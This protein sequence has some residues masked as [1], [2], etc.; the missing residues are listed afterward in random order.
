MKLLIKDGRIIDPA[1]GVDSV[2]DLLIENG[3]IKAMEDCLCV[4]DARVI[5]AAG[6]V[7]TPGFIDMHVH[8]R[9]PGYTHK[10]TIYTGTR[11]AVMG[12]ITSLACMPNT[13]P[14]IDG[15]AIVALIKEKARQEGVASVYPI[16]CVTKKCEGKELAGIASMKKAGVVALSDDGMPV[17]SSKVMRRVMEYASMFGLPIISHCEEKELSGKGVM[18]EGAM[19]T[20]LGLKGIPSAAENVMIARDIE[21]AKLTGAH[22]HIAHLSTKEGVEMVRKAKEAGINVTAEVTP[23]HF[24]LTDESLS[25]YDTNLKVN[26]PLRTAEDREEILNG[27]ADGTIDVIATDHAPHAFEDKMVEFDQAAFGMIGLETMLPLIITNLVRA[28]VLTLSEAIAK[29][30]VNPAKILGL[31]KGRLQIGED[32]DITI[33]DL[34]KER[35]VDIN[36]FQSKGKNSPFHGWKLYGTVKTVI[37]GGKIIVENGNLVC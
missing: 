23:H 29:V 5:D 32:A 21:L 20:L 30:T 34:S 31:K 6:L 15:E 28:K 1:A 9:E 25:N 37:I 22:L 18:H 35:L 24:T 10:E 2:S 14:P 16:G 26:P 36:A 4:D 12:G 17:F 27:L 3:K 7:V 19:S 11:S 8:L 33:F 13:N